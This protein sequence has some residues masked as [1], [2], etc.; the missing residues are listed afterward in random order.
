MR[1]P[2][3]IS[4]DDKTIEVAEHALIPVAGAEYQENAIVLLQE[5]VINDVGPDD[6]VER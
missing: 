6:P 5:D 4:R 3:S 2:P 1:W